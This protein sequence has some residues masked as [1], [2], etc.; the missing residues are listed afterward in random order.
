MAS[1]V[2]SFSTQL[3]GVGATQEI[4]HTLG[5][6]PKAAIFWSSAL[7][8]PGTAANGAYMIAM[9]DDD[10]DI[11]SCSW[12]STD[13]LGS[14]NTSRLTSHALQQANINETTFWAA[15]ISAWDSDSFTLSYTTQEAG[16]ARIVNYMLLGGDAVVSNIVTGTSLNGT[17]GTKAY[18]GAG[19]EPQL[20]FFIQSQ[21]D[22]D[23]LAPATNAAG[24]LG[25]TDGT[26]QGVVAFFAEDG[27]TTMDTERY[28]QTDA[29]IA[30]DF[31][32]SVGWEAGISSFDEDGFTLNWTIAGGAAVVFYALC[33][34]GL[35]AVQVGS[36]T[37]DTSTPTGSNNVTSLTPDPDVVLL[38]SFSAA[39]NASIVDNAS[40]AIGAS[41]GTNER[42]AAYFDQHGVGDS[43]TES[44]Q[45]STKGMLTE[46]ATDGAISSEADV[47]LG[48]NEFTATWTTNTATAVQ[49]LFVAIQT[50]AVIPNITDITPTTV[51]DT[52]EVVI[53]GTT[54]EVAQGTGKVEIGDN[55]VYASATL[56]ETTVSAWSDTEITANVVQGA[57]VA[58]SVWV[59]VTNDTGDVSTGFEITL[60][61]PTPPAPSIVIPGGSYQ[62]IGIRL[63]RIYAA[64]AGHQAP[65]G[66]R[67][68]IWLLGR[69]GAERG[70]NLTSG[71][72]SRID[73]LIRLYE[74]LTSSTYTG[75]KSEEMVLRAIESEL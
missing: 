68:E 35:E 24:S 49:I 71:Y 56:V 31:N 15:T 18:T 50:E 6:T 65:S 39:A 40:V 8:V 66:N 72:R 34:D 33:I 46:E 10:R 47:T 29:V 36:F 14:G 9:V 21:T 67:N 30:L 16:I 42:A 28:Q 25:F 41:D 59:F 5:V 62:S 4:A 60:E 74:N 20:C 1:V 61:E 23:P 48:T 69:I 22:G 13:A 19:F 55:S 26:N 63:E 37:K 51:Q 64:I 73:N 11:R 58:G 53:T 27:L 52:T 43:N 7:N 17:T 3:S 45:S 12:Y 57:L 2:G 54:F 32:G 70:I 44:T 38:A 75:P